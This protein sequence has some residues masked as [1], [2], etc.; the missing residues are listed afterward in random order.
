MYKESLFIVALTS[1][2]FISEGELSL[3]K[4]EVSLT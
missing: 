4:L 2:R 3:E 1:T